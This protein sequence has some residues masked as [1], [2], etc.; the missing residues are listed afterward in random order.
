MN[1]ERPPKPKRLAS[2]TIAGWILFIAAILDLFVGV[3]L[4]VAQDLLRLNPQNVVLLIED[5]NSDELLSEQGQVL[6]VGTVVTVIGLVQFVIAIGFWRV[7]T[8]AWVA[9]MTWQA[10]KILIEMATLFSNEGAWV[11][12]LLAALLVFLLNQNHV[13]RAFH[14]SRPQNEPPTPTIST[15]DIN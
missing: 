10:L 8:W 13:R 2:I 6:L 5:E 11:T 3:T 1:T 4:L 7:Q 12:V 15:S 14:I 9:A